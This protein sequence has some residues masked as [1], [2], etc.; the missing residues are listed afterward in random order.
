MNNFIIKDSLGKGKGLFASIKFEKNQVLF[1][2]EGKPLSLKEALTYP[3]IC[4]R[5]LQVGPN[6]Y[7]NVEDHFGVFTNHDCNPNS[8]IKIA[9]NAAFL[10]ASRT[11]LK[12]EEITFDYS[13]TSTETPETWSMKCDCSL[14]NCRNIISGFGLLLPA[15][16]NELIKAG[17]VPKY[18][19]EYYGL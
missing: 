9:V 12:G 3:D 4:D 2:F 1:K 14:F 7:L 15:K 13:L 8:Y 6:L 19:L 18:I 11:I 16:R 10:L 17:M 5:F